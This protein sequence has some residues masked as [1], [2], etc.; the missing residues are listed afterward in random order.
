MKDSKKHTQQETEAL[1]LHCVCQ[2]HVFAPDAESNP[3]GY[4]KVPGA[5]YWS[6]DILVLMLCGTG[7]SAHSL[8]ESEFGFA[9]LN[10]ESQ[11][12][13][14]IL[15]R[16]VSAHCTIMLRSQANSLQCALTTKIGVF[17]THTFFTVAL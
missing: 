1:S 5:Q 6:S 7:I 4:E 14:C 13:T 11:T 16:P 12:V 10:P 9:G 3:Q 15:L 8:T 17:Y 2:I